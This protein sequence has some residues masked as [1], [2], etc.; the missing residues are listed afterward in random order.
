[1]AASVATRLLTPEQY[2]HSVF[3]PDMDYVDGLLEGRNVGEWDHWEAQRALLRQ[4]ELQE[5]ACGFRIAQEVR[6]QVSPTR[7]RIS[8][9]CLLSAAGAKPNRIIREAPLLCIEVLSPEDRLP[10]VLIKVQDYFDLGVPE[11]WVIDGPA[12]RV[13]VF[14]PGSEQAFSV[15]LITAAVAGASLDLAAFFAA[16]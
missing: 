14:K 16:L 1:M 13:L 3:E 12:R 5:Q 4:L 2:L 11:V 15:G 6:V 7:F 9:T 10:R 8:D